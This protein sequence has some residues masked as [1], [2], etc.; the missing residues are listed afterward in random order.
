V[1]HAGGKKEAP[2][3]AN[4]SSSAKETYRGFQI[5]LSELSAKERRKYFDSLHAQVD[6]VESVAM[7]PDIKDYFRTITVHIDPALKHGGR[8]SRR[9]LFLAGAE[10]PPDNP[11]LLH[12]LLHVYHHSQLPDG[13]QNRDVLRFYERAK[14]SG[15]FPAD[16]YMLTNAGEY[17]AMTASVVLYGRASRPPSTRDTVKRTQPQAYAWIVREFGLVE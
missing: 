1:V 11:V 2:A 8:A 4:T 15:E 6:L 17:F 3:R 14:A 16:A 13:R 7:K 5:D 12:E 9:G 10:M